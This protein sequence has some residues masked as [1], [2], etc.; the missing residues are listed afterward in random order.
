MTSISDTASDAKEQIARL[1]EQV[2]VLMRDRVTPALADAAGRAEGAAR[3]AQDLARE[4]A[5]AWSGRVR[6]RPLVSILIAAGV[7]YLIG[8]IVR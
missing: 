3:E 1:R 4:Q 7:G 8:R 5:E 2:E 6:E